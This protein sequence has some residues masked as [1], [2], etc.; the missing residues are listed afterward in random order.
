VD[1]AVTLVYN[2]V[3]A[4]MVG[5]KEDPR[6]AAEGL[7]LLKQSLDVV[8]TVWLQAGFSFLAGGR[9]PSIADLSL[10]CDVMQLQVCLNNPCIQFW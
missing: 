3:L 4:S 8:E 10:V 2:K 7:A 6:A 9:Q 1:L 5:A